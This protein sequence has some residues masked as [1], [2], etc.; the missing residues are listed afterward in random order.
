MSFGP[1]GVKLKLARRPVQ[2]AKYP[3]QIVGCQFDPSQSAVMCFSHTDSTF[4]FSKK[5]LQN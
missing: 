2:A 3:E 1:A 5:G 4:E